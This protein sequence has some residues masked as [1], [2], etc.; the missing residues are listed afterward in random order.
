MLGGYQTIMHCPKNM[1]EDFPGS[2]Q[3]AMIMSSSAKRGGGAAIACFEPIT[4][5]PYSKI[6]DPE[7]SGS[8]T[9]I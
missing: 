4:D 8:F 1:S 9:L 3:L 7:Y 2:Q 5:M 6:L